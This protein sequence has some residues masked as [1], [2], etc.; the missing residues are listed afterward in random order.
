MF[1]RLI[2]L[3]VFGSVLKPVNAVAQVAEVRLGIAEFDEQIINFPT[4]GV[5]NENSVALTGEI[6]FEEPEFLKWALSPQPYIGGTVNLEGN[7]SFGGAG[8]LWRQ[9][10][11]DKIYGDV[12]FGLVAHTGTTEITPSNEVLALFAETGLT[13]EDITP[14]DIALVDAF[15]ARA[16]NEIEFGSRILFRQQVALGYNVDEHWAGEI[17]YEHLSNGKILSN[18]NDGVNILGARAVRK[19]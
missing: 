9:K 7:T 15:S 17:Y 3:F 18:T 14:E 11:G 8:L 19:F 13:P 1:L 16:N 5:A 10:F 4:A 6:L 12:S 2:V